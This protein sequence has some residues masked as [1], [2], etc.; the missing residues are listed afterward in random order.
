MPMRWWSGVYVF[1]GQSYLSR[2]FV[3][4]TELA[5]LCLRMSSLEA[6]LDKMLNW[7]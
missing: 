2:V 1:V 5:S 6:G 3:L 4:Y 7:M